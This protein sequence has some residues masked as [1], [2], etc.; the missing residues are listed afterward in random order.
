VSERV[1]IDLH[2][3]SRCLHRGGRCGGVRARRHREVNATA[4]RSPLPP[5]PDQ[6]YWSAV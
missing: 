5:T 4:R 3:P 1:A 6:G 2:L